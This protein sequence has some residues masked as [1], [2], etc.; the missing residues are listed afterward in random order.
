MPSWGPDL[1][2]IKLLLL[3]LSKYSDHNTP[4]FITLWGRISK[5]CYRHTDTAGGNKTINKPQV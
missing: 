3:L 5:L 1:E 4:Q 2:K